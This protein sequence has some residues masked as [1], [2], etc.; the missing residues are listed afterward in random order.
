MKRTHERYHQ[1]LEGRV[2]NKTLALSKEIPI[3]QYLINLHYNPLSYRNS[4]Y[5]NVPNYYN[6]IKSV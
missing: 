6:L 3:K 4:F 1:H 2:I 5:F